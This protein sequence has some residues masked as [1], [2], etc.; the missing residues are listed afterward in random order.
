MATNSKVQVKLIKSTIGICK[1]HCLS[2]KALGLR[3]I[4]DTRLLENTSPIQ[5]L[6]KKVGYLLAVE[7]VK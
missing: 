4:G 3:K 1:K 5:G 2:V 6:I 7:E